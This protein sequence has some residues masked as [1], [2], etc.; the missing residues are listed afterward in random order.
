MSFAELVKH[1]VKQATSGPGGEQIEYRSS[2]GSF[3]AV[4]SMW[5]TRDPI[6][7]EGNQLQ[8]TVEITISKSD[9]E[10]VA[11]GQDQVR[12][13]SRDADQPS[14]IYTVD[15]IQVET[16]GHWRLRCSY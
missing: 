12:L 10:R 11:L 16:Q 3:V 8:R 6:D 5:V 2:P 13:N 14:T 1:H 4:Y 7:I 9:V 15:T